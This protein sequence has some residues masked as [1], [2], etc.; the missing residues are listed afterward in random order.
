MEVP[1][2][3][4]HG[5]GNDFVFLDLRTTPEIMTPALARRLCHRNLG[6]GGDG[7]LVFTGSSEDPT[8][9]IWNSDGT[10]PQMCGNGIRCFVLELVRRFGIG[11]NP[12]M[13]RT[14]AGLLAC[15]W[16]DL[17]AVGFMVEVDMGPGVSG[18]DDVDLA[19]VPGLRDAAVTPRSLRGVRIS[20]GNP[21]VVFFG[22]FAEE[23][24]HSWGPLVTTSAVFEEGVNAEFA[25]ITGPGRV[26]LVVHERGAGFT[27]ACGTGA[28]A[29]VAAGV[30]AGLLAPDEVVEVALPGGILRILQRSS[31]GHLLMTGP[32]VEVFEGVIALGLQAHP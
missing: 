17:G 14:G 13:V 19:T 2:R 29:T 31:D 25:E 24:F 18:G 27:M 9:T 12:I 15:R 5:L 21:H 4:V 30:R 26:R 1:F 23:E 8:M 7:V 20:T 32:A 16:E 6:I 22:R 28:C 11:A 3:K 10:I